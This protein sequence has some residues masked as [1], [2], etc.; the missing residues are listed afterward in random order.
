MAGV[1]ERV[2][3]AHAVAAFGEDGVVHQQ[4]GVFGGDA[5]QHDEADHGCHVDAVA[6]EEQPR[7]GAADGERQCH[8][9]GE[10]LEHAVEEQ[11]E[12]GVDAEDAD[13]HR[14]HEAA[15]EFFHHFCLAFVEGAHGGR[16]VL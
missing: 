7:E 12:E 11:H 1:D 10:G 15:E 3:A 14:Q 6:E 8:E 2:E 9:D 5:H 13:A 16:Q 4:D